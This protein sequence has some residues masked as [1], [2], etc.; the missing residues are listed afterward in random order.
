MK[1]IHKQIYKQY[2]TYRS[3]CLSNLAPQ[4]IK[5]LQEFGKL[6]NH[7]TKWILG[8][9]LDYREMFQS[10]RI[11]PPGFIEIRYLL[12]F[13]LIKQGLGCQTNEKQNQ[14]LR[15]IDKS[16]YKILKSRLNS[17]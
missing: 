16:E 17:G 1:I 3:V 6:Q 5:K 10:L 7:A 9:N 8:S 4:Q 15:Q 12:S 13:C 2:I 14:N 11:I